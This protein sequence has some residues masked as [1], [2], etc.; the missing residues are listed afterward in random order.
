MQRQGVNRGLLDDVAR[1]MTEKWWIFLITGICWLI[2]GKIVFDADMGTVAAIGI[3]AGFVLI[4]A[5]LN[6]FLAAWVV[7]SW[8]WLHGIV[9]V[10]MIIAGVFAFI[11][12]DI[13]FLTLAAVLGW[14]LLFKGILN[15]IVSL[16][17]RGWELWWVGLIV[18]VIELMIGLWAA[19][20]PGRSVTLLIVWVGVAAVTRGIMEII[21]AFRLR[22]LRDQ[23]PPAAATIA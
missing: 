3:F 13:T 5:G 6:E 1:G 16:A 15:I 23:I 17:D 8:K 21:L 22:S 18:G 11:R 10:L 12:P 2:V 20:Y 4:F 14:F 7:T 9:G 19:G